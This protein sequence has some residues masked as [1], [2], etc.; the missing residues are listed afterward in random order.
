MKADRPHKFNS[1]ASPKFGKYKCKVTKNMFRAL[2]C[3]STGRHNCIIE[4]LVSSHFL[5]GL[6]VHNPLP[7]IVG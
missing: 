2:L 3:S 7:V 4:H 5:G 1:I 6:L